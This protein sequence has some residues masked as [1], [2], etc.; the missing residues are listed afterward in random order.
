MCDLDEMDALHEDSEML[1]RI[2]NN[3]ALR[4][5]RKL[6]ILGKNENPIQDFSDIADEA[7]KKAVFENDK[8]DTSLKNIVMSVRYGVEHTFKYL[9]DE[10]VIERLVTELRDDTNTEETIKLAYSYM[11][12]VINENEYD[13]L[14]V[15]IIF[16]FRVQSLF[17]W[18]HEPSNI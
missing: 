1:I 15:N 17:C 18:R 3:P 11:K 12:K 5:N 8:F 9:S 16:I 4:E 14:P 2:L 13:V 6:A 7:L 10:S